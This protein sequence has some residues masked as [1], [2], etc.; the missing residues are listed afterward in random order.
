MLLKVAVIARFAL[1]SVTVQLAPDELSQP[2]HPVN[3]ELAPVEA[4]KVIRTPLLKVAVHVL[5]QL[6]PAG[7]LVTTP[8]P[9]PASV[10]ESCWVA[11]ATLSLITNTLE[12]EPVVAVRYRVP[13]E[14]FTAISPRLNVAGT[15]MEPN[16]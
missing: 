8:L 12:T 14:E 15:G 9:V 3:T 2:F 13:V 4:F 5:P 7:L 1:V 16:I 6:M 11:W 10:T